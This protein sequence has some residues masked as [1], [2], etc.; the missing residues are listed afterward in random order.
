[1]PSKNTTLDI[2]KTLA[3]EIKAAKKAMFKCHREGVPLKEAAHRFTVDIANRFSRSILLIGFH[4]VV[5]DHETPVTDRK[6]LARALSEIL[7]N[8]QTP[9]ALYNSVGDL[10]LEMCMP[11]LDYSPEVIEKALALPTD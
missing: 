7:S 3:H 11:L 8:P 5:P 10:T 1:M 2:H 6:K 9:V 4:D